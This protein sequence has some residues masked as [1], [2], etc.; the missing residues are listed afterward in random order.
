MRSKMKLVSHAALGILLLL[1]TQGIAA[2]STALPIPL[3][4]ER[5]QAM[6]EHSPFAVASQ[7][8]A[9][10]VAAAGFAK[11][12]VLT[13]AARLGDGDFVTI[14]TRDQTQRFSIKSG[15]TYNGISVVSVAWSDAVGKTKVTLQCG[16]EFGVIGFDEALLHSAAPAGAPETA[17]FPG[18]GQPMLPPGVMMPNPNPPRTPGTVADPT[19][20][21]NPGNPGSSGNLPTTTP[22]RD[23]SIL[24]NSNLPRT[25]GTV[26]APATTMTSP[27]NSGNSSNLGN[28]GNPANLGTMGNSNTQPNPT[29]VHRPRVIRS[30]P[31]LP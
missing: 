10:P 29:P 24:P 27:G 18:T 12:L 22:L 15:E 17:P 19:A 8:P 11:D 28:A 13:G 30:L 14:T 20:L 1:H 5:Y 9:A 25:P 31:P 3:L 16:S 2:V 4:L 26:D 21:A 7:A 23:R 6:L